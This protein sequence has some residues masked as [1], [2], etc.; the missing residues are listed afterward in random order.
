M[1]ARRPSNDERSQE[2]M[3]RREESLAA[4]AASMPNLT[5]RW[6]EDSVHDVPLQRPELVAETISAFLQSI[7]TSVAA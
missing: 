3:R 6:L 1:P 4:L 2:M 5:V 7:A